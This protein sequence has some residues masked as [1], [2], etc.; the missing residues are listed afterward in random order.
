MY[1]RRTCKKPYKFYFHVKRI[2][3]AFSTFFTIVLYY[4][5]VQANTVGARA[6]I[7][8]NDYGFTLIK[9]DRLIPHL[10]DSFAF[11]IHIQQV[12]FVDEVD[13]MEWKVVLCKQPRGTRVAS[14]AKEV[15]ELECLNM[16]RDGD[17]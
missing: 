1:E 14:R 2:V 9:F 6:T 4:N 17:P 13:N 16:G 15:P 8:H 11:P 3:I 10:V 7:K 12:L 5:W